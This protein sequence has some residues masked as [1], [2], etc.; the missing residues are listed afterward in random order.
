[1]L[2]SAT[3]RA[4]I[5]VLTAAVCAGSARAAIMPY[6]QLTEDRDISVRAVVSGP[7]GDILRTDGET[8]NATGTFFR[9]MSY[10]IT[11]TS[12]APG[13]DPHAA[14]AVNQGMVFGE[15]S[16]FGGSGLDLRISGSPTAGASGRSATNTTFNVQQPTPFALNGNLA[17]TSDAPRALGMY[18]I[19][20]SFTG[21]GPAGETEQFV[22][23]SRGIPSTAGF[24][25]TVAEP[26]TSSG[27]L[28]PGWTYRLATTLTGDA[29]VSRF[30]EFPQF[31]EGNV[32]FAL[33]VPEPAGATVLVAVGGAALLRRRG[34]VTF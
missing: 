23:V 11:G 9:S 12:P 10:D 18:L 22:S 14:I 21:T 3:I 6:T 31:I 34:R 8:S 4:A 17:L 2:R 29:D 30:Y 13:T 25:G 16:I 5:V 24:G 27:T 26:F 1:M 28:L 15:T 20:F 19:A 33:T 7:D 32:D